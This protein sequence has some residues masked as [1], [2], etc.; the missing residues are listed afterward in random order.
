MAGKGGGAWKV[1]Y[2]D[3]VTAMMA[4]FMVM[5]L[6]GQ[7]AE[8]KEG[9]EQYFQHPTVQL[10]PHWVS[11]GPHEGGGSARKGSGDEEG[12]DEK[13]KGKPRRSRNDGGSAEK[14]TVRSDGNRP[15]TG[16]I[17]LFAKDSAV[18]DDTAKGDLSQLIPRLKGK[19]NRIEIRGH[20]AKR[21]LAD[22]SAFADDWQLSYARSIAVMKQLEEAGIEP[23]RLRL[24][25]AASYEPP[26]EKQDGAPKDHSRVEIF[27]LSE[28][29]DS[30]AQDGSDEH[31]VMHID[32]DDQGADHGDSH[33]E[34]DHGDGHDAKP[35]EDAHKPAAKKPAAKPS[36]SHGKP[37]TSGHG[38][39]AAKPAA[40]AHG[41]PAAGGHGAAKKKPA[42]SGH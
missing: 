20:T 34:A 35:K 2:A 31:A 29:V 6:V 41:K 5:W 8:V 32:D 14:V 18:L 36:G 3:F 10:L 27:L 13:K 17:L 9:V 4:F 33:A 23:Q 28:F 37:A 30:P 21:S 38:K 40:P 24:S 25:Q 42:K 11:R 15:L 39:P 19:T 26:D 22:Q 12:K 1:A 7:N 16:T